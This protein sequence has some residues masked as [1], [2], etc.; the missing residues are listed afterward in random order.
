MDK[1]YS[2]GLLVFI[3]LAILPVCFVLDVIF[4]DRSEERRVGKECGS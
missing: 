3:N 2:F 1:K 4:V